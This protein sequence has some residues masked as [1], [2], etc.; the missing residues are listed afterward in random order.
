MRI[1]T[2]NSEL[3]DCILHKRDF[4]F[5]TISGSWH[6]DEY[7]VSNDAGFTLYIN[8]PYEWSCYINKPRNFYEQCLYEHCKT[9][10]NSNFNF[11]SA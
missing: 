9:I 11:K 2:T 10:A 5:G 7:I 4:K 6:D 1:I 8:A 3:S